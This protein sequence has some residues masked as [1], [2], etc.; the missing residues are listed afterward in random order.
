MTSKVWISC[1]AAALIFP[2]A[3]HSQQESERTKFPVEAEL[4]VDEGFQGCEGISFNG[5]GRL[6][7]TC[8]RALYE[9]NADRSTRKISELFSNFGTAAIRER[10][11]LVADF[12]PTN[13]VYTHR[14]NR[15]TKKGKKD[16]KRK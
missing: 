3:S 16:V 15:S 12:G 4:F 1:L 11:L 5:E 13:N 14:Y 6:F 10:D 2:C 8:S 7:A 9:I